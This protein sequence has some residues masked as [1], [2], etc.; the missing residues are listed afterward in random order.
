[1]GYHWVS[2]F[3]KSI[4]DALD[5]GFKYELNRDVSSVPLTNCFEKE[6]NNLS[7]EISAAYN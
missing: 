6:F 3:T 7:A 1:M 2:F 4:F 5:G